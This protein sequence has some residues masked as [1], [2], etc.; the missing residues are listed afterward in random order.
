MFV[1]QRSGHSVW[2]FNHDLKK[3]IIYLTFLAT[4]FQVTVFVVLRIWIFLFAIFFKGYLRDQMVECDPSVNQRRPLGRVN[5][6]P[7]IS[8]IYSDLYYFSWRSEFPW[9]MFPDVRGSLFRLGQ[10]AQQ[11][12]TLNN[13]HLFNNI[14]YYYN[15]I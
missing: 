11:F 10:A 8:V 9:K 6:W 5:R 4:L 12:L 2:C 7:S 1:L 15:K 3:I 13:T 14:F